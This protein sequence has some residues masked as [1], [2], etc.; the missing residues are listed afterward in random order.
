MLSAIIFKV[1]KYTQQSHYINTFES[2][3]TK[4]W[5]A[6]TLSEKYNPEVEIRSATTKNKAKDSEAISQSFA[7]NQI[8]IYF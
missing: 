6:R 4:C 5:T 1:S 7:Y 8:T 3:F 2:P